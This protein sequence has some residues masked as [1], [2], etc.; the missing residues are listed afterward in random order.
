MVAP[1]KQVLVLSFSLAFL[2]AFAARISHA[3][4][5]SAVNASPDTTVLA[6]IDPD[7]LPPI[8]DSIISVRGWTKVHRAPEPLDCGGAL[9]A[10][11]CYSYPTR[12]L[13]VATGLTRGDEWV[14]FEH[15]K[16]HMILGDAGLRSGE[17]DEDDPYIDDKIAEAIAEYQA[18][19]RLLDPAAL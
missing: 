19:A 11:G 13:T 7:S 18:Y 12:T 5:A 1:R 4:A 16:I 10:V 2:L 9:D 17:R 8:P 15:E 14:T 3:T 6:H